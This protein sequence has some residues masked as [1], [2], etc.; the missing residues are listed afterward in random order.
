MLEEV[1]FNFSV[2]KLSPEP[3]KRSKSSLVKAVKLV[4]VQ[5]YRGLRAVKVDVQGKICRVKVTSI[6]AYISPC[7]RLNGYISA[8]FIVDL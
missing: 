3:P 8:S 2:L 4:K 7:V 1:L 6:C 5:F